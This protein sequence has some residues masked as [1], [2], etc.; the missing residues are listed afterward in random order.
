MHQKRKMRQEKAKNSENEEVKNQTNINCEEYTNA[1]LHESVEKWTFYK[2]D[3][4]RDLIKKWRRK[5]FE[6]R[7]NKNRINSKK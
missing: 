1:K 6:R 3:N 2:F 4:F 7:L 5:L